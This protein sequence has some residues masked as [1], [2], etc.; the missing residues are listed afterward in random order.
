MIHAVTVAMVTGVMVE[1][2]GE[3]EGSEERERWEKEEKAK[4][5]LRCRLERKHSRNTT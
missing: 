4:E 5:D 1:Q 3:S 2:A